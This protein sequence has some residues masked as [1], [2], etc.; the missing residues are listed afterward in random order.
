MIETETEDEKVAAAG[1]TGLEIGRDETAEAEAGAE[2]ET[3][4]EE[5]A[6]EIRKGKEEAGVIHPAAA[7]AEAESGTLVATFAMCMS[8][9]LAPYGVQCGSCSATPYV[10]LIKIIY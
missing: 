10:G 3:E 9:V 4:I 2:T 1:P 6:I 5:S 7:E 8:S